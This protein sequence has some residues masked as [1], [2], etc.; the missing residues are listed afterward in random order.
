MKLISRQLKSSAVDARDSSASQ[1]IRLSATDLSNHLACRH[2]TTL[3]LQVAKGEAPKP[4][5][6]APDLQVIR[7]LGLR[8]EKRYLT[9]LEEQ[10]KLSVTNLSHFNNQDEKALLA[11]TFRLMAEGADVIAQGALGDDHWFGRPDVLLRAEKPSGLWAWSYE[12]QDTKLAKE[13]KATTILQLSLYSDL[14]KTT[15]GSQPEFMWVI[16]PQRDFP[17]ESYRVAE[18]AAYYRHVR[19][20]LSSAVLGGAASAT[21]PEPVP[22]CDVCQWFRECE[23]RRRVDDHLSLVAGIRKQQRNQLEEWNTVTMASLSV[24][25]IPLKQRPK[26]GSREGI[27]RVREQARVQVEGRADKKLKYELLLPIA[28]GM[29]LCRL[30]EPSADDMFLDL[31]GDPFVGE[32]GLQYLFGFAFQNANG[33]LR[34]EKKWAL[35]R[36]EEKNGFE[37]VVDEIVRRR[38]ANPQTH[39]YHFGAYEPS[40]LKRLMGIYATRQ[41]EIDEMLWEGTF[42]DLHQILK[43]SARASVEEYS[44]KKIEGLYRFERKTPLDLAG[45]AMRFV[46]HQLELGWGDEELPGDIREAIEGYNS[47]DCFSTAKLRDWLE[48]RRQKLLAS[49][50]TVARLPK[51]ERPLQEDLTEW[52]QRIEALAAQLTAEIPSNIGERT[53]EQQA[54]WLLARLLDWHRREN[55]ATHWEGFRLKELDDA[56][57]LEE[58]AGLSGLKFGERLLVERKIPIDRYAF[59]KQETDAREESELYCKGEKFGSVVAIDPVKRTI[60]IKKT[61]KMTDSHPAAVYVW[62][63]PFNTKEHAESLYRLGNWVAKNGIDAVGEYRA[64]RDLLMRRPPRLPNN[65]SLAQMASETPV[66]TASRIA[67]SLKDSI[68]AIQGPPG[69]GKTYTGARMICELVK[70]GRKIGVT[71]LSHKVIRN[72]LDAVVEAAQE[73]KVQTVRCMHR[74]DD[75]EE[76]DGVAVA[77]KNNEE[78]LEALRSGKATVVGGTSWL[79][80]PELSF[81]AVD[82]LFIDEAGQMSLT[83]VL[84]VS[85]AAKNLVLLG[86]PQQLERP[87]K[88]SHPEG[89]EKSALEHLLNGRKTISEEMGFLLPESWRLHPEICKFTSEVFYE[90]KLA[91]HAIARSRVL[92]GHPWLKGAGLWFVP[93]EHDGNG[94]SS[95]EEVEVV[96]RIVEGLLQSGINWFYSAGNSWPLK[97]EEILIVA[98]YN[99]QVADL[100]ARLPG[101]RI[102]TVD[103]FQGQ[104]AAVV[105]YSLTT[106]SPEEAPRGMEFLYSLNRLNV[107]TSRAMANMIVVGSPRLFEPECRTPRQMQLANALCRFRELATSVQR[108]QL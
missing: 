36:E 5:W 2:L 85:Q 10:K 43:Q 17:G 27:E 97:R 19:K 81:Q 102:G 37:W 93:V 54:R 99:A 66:N 23:T 63:W 74:D 65:E 57:L 4:Q 88:G 35:N 61:R 7:E 82:V 101:M 70:H 28:E 87:L 12:V 69:S 48:T 16:P 90:D 49:G 72:L 15:Q 47:E 1:Q 40:V 51:T 31:E 103:K 30:P 77:S 83:D 14:L 106:S 108:D 34:Y 59:E 50:T 24:L 104:Q 6:A 91:S 107:A 80:S 11:E 60:D 8:H 26:R 89:A 52:Q 18:Y 73:M 42:V 13:T 41:D 95:P 22:H 62:K 75:G 9:F 20:Q 86:D 46:Q 76:S 45:G 64:G 58:K 71:A 67:L 96:A 105:I 100:S 78:A 21:Y 3:E 94:N 98:P 25:P 44:L 32:S 38:K 56:E 53:T 55:K 39:V 33:K 84:A 68:F 92:E 79:W 29:G